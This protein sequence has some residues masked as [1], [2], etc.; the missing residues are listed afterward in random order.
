MNII[1]R[2]EILANLSYNEQM[3]L[4]RTGELVSLL[5]FVHKMLDKISCKISLII[6]L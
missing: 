1:K 6:S 3:A 2:G 5:A 4:T